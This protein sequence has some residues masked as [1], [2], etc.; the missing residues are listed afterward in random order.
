MKTE[1]GFTLIEAAIVLAIIAVL[2]AI[3]VGGAR[4]ARRN[5]GTAGS[6]LNLVATL[7]GQRTLALLEQRDRVVVVTDASNPAGCS[8]AND[9]ACAHVWI[10]APSAAWALTDVG[11]GPST[12]ATVLDSYSLG[13]GVRLDAATQASGPAPFAA[14]KSFEAETTGTCG[15][16]TCVAVRFGANGQVSPVFTGATSLKIGW[17]LVLG[18]DLQGVIRVAERYQ[19][20]VGVPTGV[21]KY[22]AF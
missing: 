11:S 21:V 16:A 7:Q 20:I 3:T 15:S 5:A 14:V 10:L 19:I 9:A 13:T 1:R 17:S 22:L 4:A 18:S 8:W 2:A 6:A 12:N